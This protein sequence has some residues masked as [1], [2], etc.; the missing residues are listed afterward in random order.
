M[1]GLAILACLLAFATA[2]IA[3]A[4]PAPAPFDSKE[5]PKASLQGCV[6]KDPGGEPVK[7]AIVELIAENQEEGGNFSATSGAEG[8]FRIEGI[9]PGRYRVFVERTGFL[10]VDA[11]HRRS[12][13]SSL[14][15]QAGQEL[16]D[17]VLRLQPAAVILGR[18]LDEDG[19]PVPDA[20][21]TASQRR[22]SSSRF[23]LDPAGAAQTNDL[24]EYRIGG[25]AAG[26][27]YVSANPPVNFQTVVPEQKKPEEQGS[28][29]AEMSY[30]STY[31]PGTSDRAQA[32]TIELH[33]GDE[34]PVNISLLRIRAAHVRG[35]VAGLLPGT[36]GL[37][38]LRSSDSS[39]VFSAAEV[40]K[41]GKFDIPH[42][43]PG[44][45]M[46]LANSISEESP[47]SSQSS[48]EVGE[49]DVEGLRLA[50]SGGAL[51]RGRVRAEPK[52]DLRSTQLYAELRRMDGE[53]DFSE[54]V[55]FGDSNHW[56]A[57][58]KV[59]AD[60]TF[61]IKD[62]P[63]GMYEV[64]VSSS[65]KPYFVESASVGTKET[66]E[67][68][69]NVGGGTIPLD[70]V[71]SAGMGVAEGAVVNDKQQPVSS[72]VVVAVPEEQYRARP[73]R[74]YQGTT[75]QNGR[76]VI[77]AMRPGHYTLYAWESLEGDDYLD[78]EFLKRY[79]GQGLALKIEK[80]GH[81]TAALK[82]IP[83]APEGP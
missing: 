30:V 14:S 58:A 22:H 33:P 45:Y 78:P 37:V 48:L 66:V 35:S 1:R 34:T 47:Q 36:K 6:V 2:A 81:A 39:T 67:T 21:V 12:P 79:D 46:V 18:V 56:P 68:G 77:R 23:R 3:Q 74:Y 28:R 54:G 55:T 59:K 60:G 13:G 53:D 71:L 44:H 32:G 20:Q 29:A 41:D 65:A 80:S 5:E 15:L 31:Y 52:T 27:Y 82:V 7:K 17:L 38:V 62:V 69:L 25:L 64:A 61:E 49:S 73:S 10:E 51:V 24:G 11:R 43:A 40:D 70:I 50:L 42:V 63:P 83:D 9:S 16:K 72:A 26:K 8:Q 19:D 76:F 57:P 75:D 4:P